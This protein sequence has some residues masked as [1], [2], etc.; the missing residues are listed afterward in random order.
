MANWYVDTILSSVANDG[1]STDDAWDSI[2]TAMEYNGFAPGDKIWIKRDSSYLCA[3]ASQDIAPDDD[4][5][6]K[7]PIFFIGWPRAAIPDTTITQAGWTNGSNI[8][9]NVIGITPDRE[10]HVGRYVTAPDGFQYMITAVLWESVLDGIEDG[11]S[12]FTVGSNLTNTTQ[13]KYGKVWGYTDDGGTAGTIQYVRDPGSVWVENDNL[14]D[15]DAGDGE[16]AAAG[17]TAV[18]FLIDREYAGS[19]VTTTNGKFQIEADEDYTEAQA[20]DDAAFTIKLS[21]WTDDAHDLPLLDFNGQTSELL[22]TTDNCYVFRN[23]DFQDSADTSG[24]VKF[25]N[26]RAIELLGCL[27]YSTQNAPLV[28]PNGTHTVIDRCIVEGDFAAG[29]TQK[30]I[31]VIG[32]S[33]VILKNTAIYNLKDAGIILSNGGQCWLDNVNIG[34]EAPNGDED[35]EIVKNG[36]F[37]GKDVNLGGN[38]GYIDWEFYI[39]PESQNKIENYGKV[40]G[41]HRTFSPQGIVDKL[42]IVAG[43]GDPY[44]RSGGADSVLSIVFDETGPDSL[45]YFTEPHEIWAPPIFTHEFEATTASKSYRYYVQCEGIVTAAQLYIVAEYVDSYDDTSEYTMTTQQSDEAFT[46]RADAEDWAEFME[47]TGIQPAV[48]SKVRIK[49]YCSYYHATNNIFI[50]PKVE[51]S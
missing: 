40:L 26:C 30:G 32:G 33:H 41:A 42:G 16:I 49:C 17:E 39:G 3:G 31:N 51:I 10:K 15:A 43:S 23:M 13:T 1:T 36:N 27:F 2:E 20:I 12:E 7:D 25:S 34:I 21:T 8:V 37:I 5:T 4:G 18:G 28:V 6:S 38:I 50:D 47:V 11:V 14:T 44:K 45:S 19:T 29:S 48:G 22:L 46:A 9:D 35:V 24:M